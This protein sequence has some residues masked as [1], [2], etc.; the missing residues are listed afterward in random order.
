MFNLVKDNLEEA[1]VEVEGVVA[2]VQA[3]TGTARA[4]AIRLVRWN[5][6]AE[7]SDASK[8]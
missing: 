2:V 7:D 1:E 3:A 4:S 6:M 8:K 5:H